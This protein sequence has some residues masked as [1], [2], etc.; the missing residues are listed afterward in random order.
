MPV[1]K[2]LMTLLPSVPSRIFSPDRSWCHP[3][4]TLAQVV[5]K[6]LQAKEGTSA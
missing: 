2:G 4:F 5:A 1:A 3:L 6:K